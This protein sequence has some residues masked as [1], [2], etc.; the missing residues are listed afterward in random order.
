VRGDGL[1]GLI[2]P[3]RPIGIRVVTTG[4]TDVSDIIVTVEH[5]ERAEKF[6]HHQ[7]SV[8]VDP[9]RWAVHDAS[10]ER[11][12]ILTIQAED[13]DA[14]VGPVGD[15]EDLLGADAAVTRMR[16][17]PSGCATRRS[18]S[19]RT[20]IPECNQPV[21]PS[22]PVGTRLHS[23]DVSPTDMVVRLRLMA[24]AEELLEVDGRIGQRD[25][26]GDDPLPDGHLGEPDVLGDGI[27]G[28]D[29][30]DRDEATCI[31][32]PVADVDSVRA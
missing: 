2:R 7:V 19:G 28:A 32:D 14:R 27:T 18:P 16:S 31:V 17:R 30:G 4:G 1:S 22:Y 23:S 10:T 24:L 29:G 8:E 9:A 20:A 6:G 3:V 5:C 21:P 25:R 11:S 15:V 12:Q 26:I 13:D